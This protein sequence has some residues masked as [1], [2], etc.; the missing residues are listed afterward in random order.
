MCNHPGNEGSFKRVAICRRFFFAVFWEQVQGK[1]AMKRQVE[2]WNA[3]GI[4]SPRFGHL[5]RFGTSNA[6]ATLHN[7]AVT[8]TSR[9]V[10]HHQG[11]VQALPWSCLVPIHSVVMDGSLSAHGTGGP[12]HPADCRQPRPASQ[13]LSIA[14]SQNAWNTAA[15]TRARACARREDSTKRARVV[16]GGGLWALATDVH[17][18]A[19][20]SPNFPH[21][22]L[23]G[24]P[25]P[26]T[27]GGMVDGENGQLFLD[28]PLNCLFINVQKK[29]DSGAQKTQTKP[30]HNPLGFHGSSHG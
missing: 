22:Q 1:R 8:V 26:M 14:N 11:S 27:S 2:P 18:T 30:M 5:S 15:L 19:G 23:A 6:P 4:A 28:R 3:S 24:R 16:Q 20:R 13:I 21:P 29:G 12:I 25:W 9:G 17:P 10:T 7:G